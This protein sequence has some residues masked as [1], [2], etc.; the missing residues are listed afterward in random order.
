MWDTVGLLQLLGQDLR[1]AAGSG[2]EIDTSLDSSKDVK[3]F[4]EVQ[5][6]Q[7]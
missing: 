4:I 6:L 2:A 3:L 5:K 1:P 7:K